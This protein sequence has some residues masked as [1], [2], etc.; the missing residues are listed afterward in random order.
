MHKTTSKRAPCRRASEH[1]ARNAT[2]PVQQSDPQSAA[3]ALSKRPKR[4]TPRMKEGRV[5]SPAGH[6]NT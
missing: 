3:A 5:A 6:N 1:H 2:G 4:Q